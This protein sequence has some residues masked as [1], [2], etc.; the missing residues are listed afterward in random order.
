MSTRSERARERHLEAVARGMDAAQRAIRATAD[1]EDD[2]ALAILNE[3]S[4]ED[5][6]WASSYLLACLRELATVTA[7]GDPKEARRLLHAGAD[8]AA[9]DTAV[10]Q[11]GVIINNAFK[12]GLN[13]G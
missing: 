11:V 13:H 5:A 2:R 3:Q 7:K 1:H 9:E 12:G 4:Y 8:G 10:T 6:V